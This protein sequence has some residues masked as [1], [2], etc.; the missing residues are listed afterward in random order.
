M[1]RHAMLSLRGGEPSVTSDTV[2]ENSSSAQK[3]NSTGRLF[4]LSAIIALVLALS[5]SLALDFSDSIFQSRLLPWTVPL[6]ELQSV[7]F[8]QA[9]RMFPCRAEGFDTGCEWYKTLPTFVAANALAYLS[10]AF[11]GA[12]LYRRSTRLKT[13]LERGLHSVVRWGACCA[14]VGLCLRL[15][16]AKFLLEQLSAINSHFSVDQRRSVARA[17]FS[18]NLLCPD[19]VAEFR[20]QCRASCS[21]KL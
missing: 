4:G 7:G 10:I 20:L 18:T 11:V 8:A 3:P 2:Y 16:V 14:I 13:A 1:S 9:S 21:R 15:F 5:A 12:Y 17:H 19:R 6:I